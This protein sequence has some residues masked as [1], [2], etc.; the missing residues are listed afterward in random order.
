MTRPTPSRAPS[1][2]RLD[3]YPAEGPLVS[4]RVASELSGLAL[5]AVHTLIRSGDVRTVRVRGAVFVRLDDVEAA[6]PR[7]GRS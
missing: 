5:S 7:E 4:P 1:G 3:T 6:R 2:G